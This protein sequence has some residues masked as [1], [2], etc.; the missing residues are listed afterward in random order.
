MTA[1]QIKTGGL[2]YF[3]SG[4]LYIGAS[5]FLGNRVLYAFLGLGATALLALSIRT[6]GAYMQPDAEQ[7]ALKYGVWAM[8]IG[9]PFL[10]GIYGTAYVTA[11]ATIPESTSNILNIVTILVGSTLTYGVA[12]ALIAYSGLKHSLV[13]RWL[14]WVGFIGGLFGLLWAGWMW[15]ITPE[16]ILFLLPSVLLTY[17]WQLGMGVL[18]MRQKG[19]ESVSFST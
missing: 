9:V 5:V 11:V 15:A 10:I 8:L 7:K 4:L 17:I 13:P 18:L 19:T 2:L 1:K 14:S 12:P 6:V 16:N 3:I